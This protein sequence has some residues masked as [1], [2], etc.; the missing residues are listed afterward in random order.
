MGRQLSSISRIWRMLASRMQVL[1][2]TAR[3]GYE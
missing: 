1:N 2:T 3:M